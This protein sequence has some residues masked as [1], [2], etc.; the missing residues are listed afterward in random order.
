MYLAKSNYTYCCE[1]ELHYF[2][3]D[4]T[5]IY[6]VNGCSKLFDVASS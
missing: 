4:F 3:T 2:L 5:L 1:L 6:L